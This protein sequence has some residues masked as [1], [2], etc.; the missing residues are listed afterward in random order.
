MLRI[1]ERGTCQRRSCRCSLTKFTRL[2]AFKL[3]LWHTERFRASDT[4]AS[5]GRISASPGTS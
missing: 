1:T 5:A 2:M 3:M 4:A